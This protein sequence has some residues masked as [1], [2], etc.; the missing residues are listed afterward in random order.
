[1]TILFFLLVTPQQH[2]DEHRKIEENWQKK[3]YKA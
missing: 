1:M 3:I 2:I